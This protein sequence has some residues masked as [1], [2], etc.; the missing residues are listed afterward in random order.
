MRLAFEK[1]QGKRWWERLISWR[2]SSDVSHVELLFSDG[3]CFSTHPKDGASRFK[4]I[5]MDS[6]WI[7]EPVLL[8]TQDR[9]NGLREWCKERQGIPYGWE[10]IAAIAADSHSIPN[11]P[12]TLIC[13]ELCKAGLQFI[14]VLESTEVPGMTDP[15]TLLKEIRAWNSAV[16]KYERTKT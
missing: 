3:I 11:F 6:R 5:E 14:G 16:R 4:T 2:M 15:G 12:D 8:V 1:A 7:I 10:T 9:E 13:S